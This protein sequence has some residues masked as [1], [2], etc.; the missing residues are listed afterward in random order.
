MR[1]LTL[2]LTFALPGANHYLISSTRLSE[3]TT[4][5][6]KAIGQ[7]AG[8][9]AAAVTRAVARV[10]PAP[11]RILRTPLVVNMEAD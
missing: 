2:S 5:L 11:G 10:R 7:R 1:V 8:Q 4:A 6:R 3:S 9:R